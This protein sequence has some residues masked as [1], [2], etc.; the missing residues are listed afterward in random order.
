VTARVAARLQECGRTASSILNGAPATLSLPACRLL[1]LCPR[2][3]GFARWIRFW[4][5]SDP[6][7]DYSG[8]RLKG[9]MDKEPEG[10]QTPEEPQV[11]PPPF[12][13][14]PR[15]VTYLERGRKPDAERRFRRA[16]RGRRRN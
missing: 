12:Q 9:S 10:P 6:N 11:E 8:T 4:R 2:N 7:E 14:D 16:I 13:P 5:K 15:L 1:L 3:T